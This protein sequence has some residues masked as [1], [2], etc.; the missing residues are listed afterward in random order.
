MKPH[1]SDLSRFAMLLVL[2]TVIALAPGCAD[3]NTPAYRRPD[4]PQAHECRRVQV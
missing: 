2:G 4:A 1:R 3:V